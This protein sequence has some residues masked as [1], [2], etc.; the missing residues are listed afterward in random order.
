MSKLCKLVVGLHLFEHG[1]F[2]HV[3][4][5][6][7]NDEHKGNINGR[8]QEENR[9]LPQ[10]NGQA[11]NTASRCLKELAHSATNPI[12]DLAEVPIKVISNI[13]GAIL[14]EVS[15]FLF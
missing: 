7:H 11:T 4:N 13:T 10:R 5:K 15:E 9:A 6:H 8:Y 14:F 3:S 12:D 2:W 1:S